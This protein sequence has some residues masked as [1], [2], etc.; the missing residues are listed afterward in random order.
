MSRVRESVH[1]ATQ[2]ERSS[3]PAAYVLPLP[4]LRHAP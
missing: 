3:D 4:M 1:A 2:R